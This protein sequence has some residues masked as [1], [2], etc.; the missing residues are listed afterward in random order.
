MKHVICGSCSLRFPADPLTLEEPHVIRSCGEWHARIPSGATLTSRIS[1]V[2]SSAANASSTLWKGKRASYH[3]P[4]ALAE[5]ILARSP[6]CILHRTRACQKTSCSKRSDGE[7]FFRVSTDSSLTVL[8]MSMCK[9][10]SNGRKLPTNVEG[11]CKLPLT[12][13]TLSS[14]PTHPRSTPSSSSLT[15]PRN[16]KPRCENS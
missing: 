5:S 15:T 9:P 7:L 14:K 4:C 11:T 8:V 13:R 2:M 6:G 16:T 3:A 10:V 1:Q 12:S